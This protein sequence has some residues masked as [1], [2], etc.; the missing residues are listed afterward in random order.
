MSD[1][2]QEDDCYCGNCHN[3]L[4][5]KEKFC[6]YCGTKRGEG[7]FDPFDNEITC[8]YGPPVTVKY[9]CKAC[10][11]KWTVNTLGGDNSMY[12]PECG[13]SPIT[14]ISEEFGMF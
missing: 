13:K 7:K 14:K 4:G 1:R 8:V 10:G 2:F 12:C 11:N 3:P 6:P 5:E 9:K